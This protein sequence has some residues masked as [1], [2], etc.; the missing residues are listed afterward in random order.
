MARDQEVRSQSLTAQNK[1]TRPEFMK[2]SQQPSFL[3]GGELRDYQLE[4]L[5]WLIYSWCHH[6]N[7]ILADEMGLGKTVQT[8]SFICNRSIF[9]ICHLLE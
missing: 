7:G 1:T 2:L 3:V 8:L 4:G 5:N 6:T 9:V